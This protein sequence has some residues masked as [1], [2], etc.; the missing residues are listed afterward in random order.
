MFRNIKTDAT[1]G[2][3]HTQP[4]P[5]LL[6]G[7]GEVLLWSQWEDTGQLSQPDILRASAVQRATPIHSYMFNAQGKMIF[8]NA[9]A[10]C[11]LTA[12]GETTFQMQTHVVWHP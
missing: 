3:L 9:Q 11:A 5:I 2:D 7:K 1:V 4:F 12:R 6:D 8:A 10:R